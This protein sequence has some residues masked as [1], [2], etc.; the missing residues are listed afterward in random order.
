MVVVDGEVSNR[1]SILSGFV[2][3]LSYF[4]VHQ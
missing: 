2:L 4:N 1:K 3:G